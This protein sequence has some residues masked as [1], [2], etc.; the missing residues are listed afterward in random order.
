MFIAT[1]N[2]PNCP[3]QMNRPT[4]TTAGQRTSGRGTKK[5]AGKA[6][7]PKRRAAKS[8]GGNAS[9]REQ[10]GCRSLRMMR[11]SRI[12]ARS[13]DGVGTVD[14][15]HYLGGQVGVLHARL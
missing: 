13:T 15:Q 12:P 11:R 10:G 1:N 5:I 8:S 2:R 3:T 14:E 4:P 9:A 7:S 6:I